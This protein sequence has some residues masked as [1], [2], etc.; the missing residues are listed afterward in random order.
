MYQRHSLETQIKSTFLL[1]SFQQRNKKCHIS[2]YAIWESQD[3]IYEQ[4]ST[5]VPGKIMHY[6]RCENKAC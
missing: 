1:I 4:N 6:L 5:R 3:N 2:Y